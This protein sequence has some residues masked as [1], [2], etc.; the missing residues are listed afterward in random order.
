MKVPDS[1]GT[2]PASAVASVDLPLPDSP[3]T[4]SVSRAAIVNETPSTAAGRPRP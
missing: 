2:S 1:A 4:A 3:T